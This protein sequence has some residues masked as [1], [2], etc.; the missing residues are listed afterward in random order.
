MERK[1][2]NEAKMKR[3]KKIIRG[4]SVGATTFRLT[5]LN[6]MTFSIIGQLATLSIYDTKH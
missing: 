4:Q 6:T 5:T 2:L 3:E 1:L